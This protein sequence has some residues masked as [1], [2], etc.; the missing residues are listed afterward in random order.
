ME[1]LSIIQ[2][3]H[4]TVQMATVGTPVEVSAHIICHDLESSNI[5]ECCFTRLQTVE[6]VHLGSDV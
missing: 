6:L 5:K 4:V 1:G 2:P 3:V